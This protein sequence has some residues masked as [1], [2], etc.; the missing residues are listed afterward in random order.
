MACPF[1]DESRRN[2][3]EVDSRKPFSPTISGSNTIRS[4]WWSPTSSS[5]VII[6]IV[7]LD[8]GVEVSTSRARK[9]T[10]GI[11]PYGNK[12]EEENYF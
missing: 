9:K 1:L 8:N 5:D 7:T 2:V 3:G 4:P 6:I 11:W 12:T 10:S